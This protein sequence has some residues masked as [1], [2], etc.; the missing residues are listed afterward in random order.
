MPE[1]FV[2]NVDEDGNR[3]T[4]AQAFELLKRN[5][6]RY[7]RDPIGGDRTGP[8]LTTEKP[9]LDA[10]PNVPNPV[11]GD[12]TGPSTTSGPREELKM[13]PASE[14]VDTSEYDRALSRLVSERDMYVMQ[15]DYLKDQ[16][17][18]DPERYREI[19]EKFP[20]LQSDIEELEAAKAA[21]IPFD[22]YPTSEFFNPDAPSSVSLQEM[23][24]DRQGPEVS[25]PELNSNSVP[26]ADDEV[27]EGA[28][29]GSEEEKALRELIEKVKDDRTLLGSI[30]ET[31][32]WVRG[33]QTIQNA[34][35]QI[36][37]IEKERE[38]RK[39]KS[40]PGDLIDLYDYHRETVESGKTLI[41]DDGTETTVYITGLPVGDMIYNVPGYIRETGEKLD[42]DNPKDRQRLLEIWGDD[43]E[44]G[45]FEGF[46]LEFYGP[47][48]EHPAN[49]RVREIKKKIN[50]DSMKVPPEYSEPT[51]ELDLQGFPED[52]LQQ[53]MDFEN[54]TGNYGLHSD[55]GSEVG[56]RDRKTLGFGINTEDSAFERRFRD[57]TGEDP[58]SYL[59]GDGKISLTKAKKWLIA[60]LKEAKEDARKRVSNF[61]E[62]PPPAQL[63]LTD[64]A[65]QMGS[66]SLGGFSKMINSIET[67]RWE[68]AIKEYKN[69][70]YYSKAKGGN[71]KRVKRNLELFEEAFKQE[72]P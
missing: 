12:M 42:G 20:S 37:N 72:K 13:V 23:L 67:G 40:D 52:F 9:I 54:T 60:Y 2:P 44:A 62:L 61:D 26:P 28:P 68:D 33:E 7:K 46:P 15:Y 70:D 25:P 11:G 18:E 29:Y 51:E 41:N 30:F 19:E 59:A 50:A 48:R 24:N 32:G 58:S 3:I 22:D 10:D 27:Q 57:L 8:S 65:F 47:I 31:P 17:I 66:T 36:Q 35:K 39:K 38:A 14:P 5:P 53:Q 16:G 21:G 4:K 69:S 45:R 63:A 43:I 6:E 64:M 49:V 56:G 55:R 34:L 71:V 1:Y